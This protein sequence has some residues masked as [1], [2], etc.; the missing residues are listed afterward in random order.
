MELILIVCH[1]HVAEAARKLWPDAITVEPHRVVMG[2]RADR[3]IVVT[4][5]AHDWETP[6]YN[7]LATSLRPAG[8]IVWLA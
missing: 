4:G 7:S 1:R 6:W 2:Y 5:P 8:D 3:I